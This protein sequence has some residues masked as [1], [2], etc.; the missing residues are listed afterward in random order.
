[1][2]V[3]QSVQ[4]E[5]INAGELSK[6]IS[7]EIKNTFGK[8]RIYCLRYNEDDNSIEMNYEAI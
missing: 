2:P 6:M 8:V 3:H 5:A 4:D 1:M 7:E